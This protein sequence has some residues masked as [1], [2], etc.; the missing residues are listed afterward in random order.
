MRGWVWRGLLTAVCWVGVYLLWIVINHTSLQS[1]SS[2]SSCNVARR[3]SCTVTRVFT[4]DLTIFTGD[5]TICTGD[6]TIFTGDLTIFT[7]DLTIFTGDLT[8]FTGDL[9]IFT[10]DLTNCFS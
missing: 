6:L 10:G 5:L 2:P 9:T 1:S 7:S 8:I 4:G 3:L